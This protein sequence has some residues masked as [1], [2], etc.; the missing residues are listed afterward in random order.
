MIH[1][2]AILV[3]LFICTPAIARVIHLDDF[4]DG[5]DP[6]WMRLDTTEPFEFGPGVFDPSQGALNLRT[7]GEVPTG[8]GTFG[9]FVAVVWS[10][11]LTDPIFS[12]G[13][14]RA[15]VRVDE[16]VSA[17]INLRS[18][19]ETLSAYTFN[20]DAQSGAISIWKFEDTFGTVLGTIPDLEFTRGDYWWLE[21][22]S[23]ETVHALKAWRDGSPEPA[24]PQLAV[25][26]DTFSS[27]AIGIGAT[28]IQGSLLPSVVNATFDDVSFTL[29]EPSVPCDIDADGDCDANDLDELQYTGLG[30]DDLRF[31]LNNDGV[32]DS[33]DTIAW[34]D[35]KGTFPGDA[36]LDGDVDSADLNAVG[37]NWQ[38]RN[39]LSWADGDFDGNR[40]VDSKDLNLLGSNW[41]SGVAA[42]ASIVI[43]EPAGFQWWAVATVW[44]LVWTRSLVASRLS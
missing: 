41:Q 44:F 18:N 23:F 34:L 9:G 22:T 29:P 43:P 4:S 36:D 3:F 40:I 30:G 35:Q 15:R 13:S 25:V 28:L 19:L 26:D 2:R 24:T 38:S 7:T 17:S 11:S 27:G 31:D 5:I 16:P 37:S 20:V 33:A 8:P 14:M 21:A 1:T 6:E 42:A 12:N 39:A 10:D 32:V